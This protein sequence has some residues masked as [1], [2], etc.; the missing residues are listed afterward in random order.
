M[1][2]TS[3]FMREGSGTFFCAEETQK[4]HCLMK[5]GSEESFLCSLSTDCVLSSNLTAMPRLGFSLPKTSL[6]PA[7]STLPLRWKGSW[8]LALL[9]EDRKKWQKKKGVV[10]ERQRTKSVGVPTHRTATIQ[11]TSFLKGSTVSL[12]LAGE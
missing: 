6:P 1:S 8:L 12:R 3:H 4:P 5:G 2:S 11:G 10:E 7:T 9:R